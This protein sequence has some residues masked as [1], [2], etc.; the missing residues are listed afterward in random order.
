[1]I[2]TLKSTPAFGSLLTF[3][4]N[5]KDLSKVAAKG[6]MKSI[7]RHVVREALRRHRTSDA[8]GAPHTGHM[9]EGANDIHREEDAVVIPILGFDRVFRDVDIRPRN[10]KALTIPINALSYAKRAADM[11]KFGLELFRRSKRN[12]GENGILYGR[13]EEGNVFSLY[14]LKSHVT[15]HKDRS[16]LPSDD[17]MAAAAKKEVAMAVERRALGL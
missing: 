6:L 16:L 2:Y 4:G 12:G 9:E 1:M 7:R 11:P 13:D 17:A 14:A 15:L 8:L 5:R 3:I 10:A